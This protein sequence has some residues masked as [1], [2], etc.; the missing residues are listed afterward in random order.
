MEKPVFGI[1]LGANRGVE[2]F[3]NHRVRTFA[4]PGS[5]YVNGHY[6]GYKYQCVEY[7]RRWLILVKNLT[8]QSV[9]CACNIWG[10]KF[11]ENLENS[12]QIPLVPLANG[13]K[14]PPQPSALLIYKR[15][16]GMPWGHVAIITEV[17]LEQGYIRVAGQNEED[18]HWPGDYSRQLPLEFI[19][20]LYWVR[21]KYALYG[22]MVYEN[23]PDLPV[24]TS[25]K[26]VLF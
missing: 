21:D 9:P 1:V 18:D 13:S 25:G 3:S 6:A 7:A 19:D 11:L 20:N 5:S 23:I 2:G 14:F 15:R 10:I 26:C 24:E 4:R 16:F 8:F 22:W 17:N 12:Q